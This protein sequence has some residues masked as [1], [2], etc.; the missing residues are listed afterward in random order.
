[1][2]SQPSPLLVGPSGS[3]SDQYDGPQEPPSHRRTETNADRHDH[4]GLKQLISQQLALMTDQ[5]AVLGNQSPPEP[6]NQ[7]TQLERPPILQTSADIID[8]G[9]T[10]RQ[11]VYLTE[12]AQGYNE[13][14]KRSKECANKYRSVLADNR[15]SAGFRP[16]IKE[17]LYPIVGASAAGSHITDIDG[18]DYIDL[19]MGFGV[20]LAGH[21]PPFLENGIST[22]HRS[23]L[24]LGP[25]S[26]LAGEVAQLIS[27][28]TGMERVTFCNTGT[29]AVMTAIRLAR[30]A[31]GRSRIALFSGSYH[32][33]FDGVLAMA[34][35]TGTVPAT[36]GTLDKFVE[37]ILIL[38]Y[39][40]DTALSILR[41]QAKSLAAIL[42]EPV[43]S[44]A[45]ALQPRDFLH[46]LREI[47]HQ[48]GTALIFDEMLT[49]F[50]VTPAG[51]QAW[52][53]V[54]ADLATYGKILGGGTPIGIVAGDR[55]F[56]NMIDGGNWGYGD[57]SYPETEKIFFAGTFNK[58]GTSIAAAH[59]IL[60]H[61][62]QQGPDL[63]KKLNGNTE[64][65]ACQ[66]NAFC[67]EEGFP[68]NVEYFSSFFRFSFQ[69]NA[70]IF[71]FKLIQ[72]G[73]YIWEGRT[74]F[75]STAHTAKDIESIINIVKNSLREMRD[76]GFF[77][78]P[79]SSKK[80]PFNLTEA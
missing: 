42:V 47:T 74:C 17:M 66:L 64:M 16:S 38:D 61:L 59:S 78:L 39:G 31:T 60:T 57:N 11:R 58:N 76:G 4:A 43:Q 54:K 68:L 32:G 36:A 1:M 3:S 26:V 18:N 53:D 19:T 69:G 35:G 71:F 44:R 46:A 50:R 80:Q 75:L 8:Y 55:R 48:S 30:A 27:E 70:D 24:I 56:L 51:A 25:I 6:A 37:E 29:E 79:S 63:Q 33:H 62:K 9:L 15:R 13:T 52:F 67:T 72:N 65:L 21:A 23:G 12:F 2:N 45:P 22:C 7:V 73:I 41:E 49:G 34:Q 40:S 5:L 77:P 14:H 10:A 20:L 28:M